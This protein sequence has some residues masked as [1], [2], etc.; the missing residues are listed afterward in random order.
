MQ[1]NL[2][3]KRGVLA[4]GG[5]VIAVSH[6]IATDLRARAP[7]LG[8]TRIEVIPNAVNVAAIRDVARVP[9]RDAHLAEQMYAVYVGK[10]APNKGTRHLID[11]I[12]RADLDWPLIVVGDGP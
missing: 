4:R 5:A 8:S 10:L 2:A 3:G 6:R 7:E 9:S 12:T 11:V 1:S